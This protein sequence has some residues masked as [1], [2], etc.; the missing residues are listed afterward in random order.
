MIDDPQQNQKHCRNQEYAIVSE[1]EMTYSFP[2]RSK[3]YFN[4]NRKLD[5]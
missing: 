3:E 4:F 2:E 5:L 1:V